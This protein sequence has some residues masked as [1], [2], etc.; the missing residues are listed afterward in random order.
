MNN[1]LN[2][3]IAAL[4]LQNGPSQIWVKLILALQNVTKCYIPA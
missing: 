3:P 4:S 1:C 2:I